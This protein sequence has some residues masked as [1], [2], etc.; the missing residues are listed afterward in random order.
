MKIESVRGWNESVG[1]TR[2]YS[3]AGRRIEAVSLFYVEVVTEDDVGIGSAS[4]SESVTG[5]SAAACGD[6]LAVAAD[7]LRGEDVTRIGRL[8]Q[9]LETHLGETPAARAAIDMAL[10]DVFAKGLGVPVVDL[11]GAR[12]DEPIATSITVGIQSVEQAMADAEEYLQRGFRC[13]KIKIGDDFAADMERLG[14]LRAL[15]DETAGEGQVAIRVDGNH[16]FDLE[17]LRRLADGAHRLGVEL[18]EQP[19]PPAADDELCAL[20]DDTRALLAADE[21]LVEER[22]AVGL[23]RGMPYR[24][25]NLKLMKHGGPTPARAIAH[26]AHTAGL[27]LMWGCMDESVASIAAALHAAYASPAT[28]RLDLDGSFDLADDRAVGGFRLENGRLHLLDEPGLGVAW[29]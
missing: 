7:V 25:W 3:I 27:G 20:P 12:R 23:L 2:P 4:P 6:A 21:S 26:L 24:H 13:L 16:G 29:A 8:Q 15:A 5:E 1:L 9:L 14:A 17:E 28:E 10:W 11:W 18:V 22:H 19:V